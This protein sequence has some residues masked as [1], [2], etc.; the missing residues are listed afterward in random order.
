METCSDIAFLYAG[1][2]YKRLS[3][4]SEMA[5]GS[6][7]ADLGTQMLRSTRTLVESSYDRF[8]S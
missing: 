2:D 7:P 1:A 3:E 8:I 4:M 6:R 5:R